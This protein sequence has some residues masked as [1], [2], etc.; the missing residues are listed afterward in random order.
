MCEPACI[1][2]I[3]GSTFECYDKEE[4]ILSVKRTWNSAVKLCAYL[5]KFYDLDPLADGVLISHKEGHYRGIASGHEDPS[6][7]W[8]QLGMTNYTMD[9]FR[10][11][12][13]K[14]MCSIEIESPKIENI[15]ALTGSNNEEKIWNYLY[16]NIKNNYGVAGLMGN[17]YAESGLCPIN[18]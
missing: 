17:L 2:Y 12:V 5:C 18:L 6:H 1:K 3:S 4:A 16:N 7:L 11:T 15:V 10:S 14:A 8:E 13:K 9:T